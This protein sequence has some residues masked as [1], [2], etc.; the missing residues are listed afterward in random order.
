MAFHMSVLLPFMLGLAYM[1]P[2]LP[3][4]TDT[5]NKGTDSFLIGTD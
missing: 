5:L 2:S 4:N 1:H 3:L